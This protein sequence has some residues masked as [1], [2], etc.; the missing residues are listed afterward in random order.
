MPD[1]PLQVEALSNLREAIPARWAG[2]AEIESQALGKRFPKRPHLIAAWRVPGVLPPPSHD[3]IVAVDRDFPW[4]LPLI[5][6]PDATN[7]ISL[8][9][10][11]V[12]GHLCLAP[13]GSAYTLPVRIEHVVQ[14]VKDACD[15]IT[16]GVASANDDDFYAEAQSY[17]TLIGNRPG[18]I[19]L[20]APPPR[21]HTLWASAVAGENLVIGPDKKALSEWSSNSGR[22]LAGTTQPALVVWLPEPLHPTSYP[23]MMG[24]LTS[25]IEAAGALR[26]LHSAISRW[27]ARRELP[28]VL[29]FRHE[30]TNVYLGAIYLAPRQVRMPGARQ[31]GIRGFRQNARGRS[32]VRL[33]ALGVVPNPFPHLRVV[34][35]HR[36]FLRERTAGAAANA[37][38]NQHVV[39]AGCGAIGGQLAVQLAQAGVGRLTLLDPDILTW[40]NVG[41]HV[42]DSS[43]VGRHK[44]VALKDAIHRRFPDAN[45]ESEPRSWQDYFHSEGE[46]LQRA[47]L[48]ISVT[49]DAAGNLLLDTLAANG[50]IPAV[51]FGWIEPFGVAAHAI[52]C[53]MGGPRLADISE[54]DGRL[55]EPVADTR[56]APSLP[57][58]P[59][60][61]AF[62]QPYS[63]L[64]AL[65]SV[66]LVGELAVDL[67]LGRISTSMHRVWVGDADAF[68]RNGLS[69]HPEW[70]PRL[71]ALGYNRR[72][73]LTL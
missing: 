38:A 31:N 44:A 20:T 9:H 55:L 16:K 32:T 39:I 63:S 12:D 10:V 54:R 11:E 29:A 58:E 8:P 67:M 71:N 33:H 27:H 52:C 49:G 59:A 18:A 41:R 47:D 50:E 28:V 66:A 34:Q 46:A 22:K 62:Y 3:V 43:S 72:Y 60:C 57:R 15:A 17:W 4:S 1:V 7:A 24:E 13:A 19:W 70:H 14:L 23:S 73:D 21:Q 65:P 51:L 26:E 2:A 42:L 6:L 61:G 53:Q 30:S 37:L 69:I 64:S 5:A 68:Q 25:L 45:V 56:S 36:A 48:M 35:V 40:Q